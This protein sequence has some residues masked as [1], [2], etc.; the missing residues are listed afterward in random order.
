MSNDKNKKRR[1]RYDKY[2]YIEIKKDI[3]S[4]DD[5]IELGKMYSLNK[6]K[7]IILI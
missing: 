1:T 7:G 6:E 4:I 3:N 5:L 2:E